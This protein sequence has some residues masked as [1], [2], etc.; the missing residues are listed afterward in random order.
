MR[1][2]TDWLVHDHRKYDAAL[3][4]CE[5]AAGAGDWRA[6]VDLFRRFAD[7]LQLHMRMEDEVVYPL[8]AQQGDPDGALETL[9][10]EHEDIERLLR[11][12]AYVVKRRDFDHFLDS[13]HPL[14]RSMARHN[15]HEEEVLG[16]SPGDVLLSRQEIMARLDAVS[17]AAG[18]ER[19]DF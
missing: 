6:A 14:R 1:E 10:E 9:R 8:F 19:F 2:D 7:D 5:L 3:A 13:L 11:D 12:L 17:R 4:E 16:G 15:R 18:R